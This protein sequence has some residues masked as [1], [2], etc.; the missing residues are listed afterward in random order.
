M[1]DGDPELRS[2]EGPR[3]GRVDVAG[4]DAERRAVLEEN[5]LEANQCLCGLLRMASGSHPQEDVGLR[6][7]QF[8]EEH[9]RH[10]LVV[11]LPGVDEEQLDAVVA[12]RERPDDRCGLHEVRASADDEA[13][14][15][16]HGVPPALSRR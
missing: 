10:S 6:K 11:V 13:D 8:L 7:L 2:R 14:T 1:R 15:V 4:H 16:V 5:T 9:R 3:E 12:F